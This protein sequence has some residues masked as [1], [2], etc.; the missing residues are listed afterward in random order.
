MLVDVGHPALPSVVID[1]VLGGELATD[2]LIARGHRRIGFVGDD[3]ARWAS[4]PASSGGAACIAGSPARMDIRARRAG[5]RGSHGRE[6][7]RALAEQLMRAGRPAERDLRRLRPASARRA[8]GRRDLGLRVPE[9]LAVIGFDDIEV[10]AMLGLSTVRQPLR[11]SGAQGPRSCSRGSAARHRTVRGARTARGRR[12]A[13]RP[14]R[15]TAPTEVTEPPA[16]TTS[17]WSNEAGPGASGAP[18]GTR[19]CR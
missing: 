11:E 15:R 8:R 2:H 10:A 16:G 1:D 19:G 7:A 17:A 3:L 13:A 9:D 12:R 5:A 14:E 18:F 4:A 6:A